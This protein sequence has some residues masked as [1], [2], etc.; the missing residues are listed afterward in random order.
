MASSSAGESVR[1]GTGPGSGGGP[2]SG[3]PEFPRETGIRLGVRRIVARGESLYHSAS[4][5]RAAG[6]SPASR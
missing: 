5:R 1:T 4:V 6:R 3:L 2:L